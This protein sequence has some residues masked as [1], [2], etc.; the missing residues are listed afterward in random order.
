M[1]PIPTLLALSLMQ[2]SAHGAVIFADN[3]DRA[4]LVEDRNIDG[5]LTGITDN[6][7]SSLP[8][9]GVYTHGWID[10]NNNDPINGIQDTG[11]A[12]NGPA[13]GGGSRIL[14]NRLQLAVGQGTSNAFVNHNFINPAILA[15]GGF[16]VTL[17][18]TGYN[19]S[20]SN[21]QGGGFAIGMSQAEADGS[22]D[23][24]D[25]AS[26][27]TGAFGTLIG[28]AVPAQV[29]SD[30]WIAIRGNNSLVWGGDTGT[31]AGVTGLAAKTGTITVDFSFTSFTLGSLVNYEV[32]LNSVSQ[33]TGT[34][35]WSGTDENYIGI[36][37]RDDTGVGFDNFAVTVVPEP[38][39]AAL[40]LLGAVALLRRRR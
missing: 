24:F 5:S 28:A 12:P 11:A 21:G 30:F 36:D 26:R 8:A 25:G 38:S 37:A 16:S 14:N 31:V 40:G 18:V 10:P 39:A 9:N 7:G 23:A 15:A 32:Y 4:D 29:T 27:M 34:F 22:G 3:F 1:K 13:N 35:T 2:A 19:Q 17:D 20:G 33:G 6:T